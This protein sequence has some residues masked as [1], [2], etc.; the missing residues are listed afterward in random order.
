[1]AS[2]GRLKPQRPGLPTFGYCPRFPIPI[3]LI[4]KADVGFCCNTR[5]YL[6]ATLMNKIIIF[7]LLWVPFLADGQVIRYVKVNGAGD[8]SNWDNASGDLQAMINASG[9][10]AQVWVAQGEYLP[11]D[12]ASFQMKNGVSVYGGFNTTETSLDQRDFRLNTTTLK[13]NGNRVVYNS[14]SVSQTAILDGF[15]ITGGTLTG[16][17][18]NTYGAGIWND[19][20]SA[21]ILNCIIR[22]NQVAGTGFIAKGGGIANTGGSPTIAR[23]VFINNRTSYQGGAIYNE[24][25]T[26]AISNCFF[27]ENRS[28]GDGTGAG[29][30]A[31]FNTGMY[32]YSAV[33]NCVFYAN[34]AQRGGL[35]IQ[36]GFTSN[37]NHTIANC[38]FY[39]NTS[40]D[41]SNPWAARTIHSNNSTL[42]IANT[43]IWNNIGD[44]AFSKQNGS[45]PVYYNSL[46][47]GNHFS[48]DGN[49]DAS[50]AGNNPLF[51][52]TADIA[53]AD[54]FY[55]TADDGLAL[56][57]TS[58]VIDK[59]N[60]T[61][62]TSAG[63]ISTGDSD[64]GNNPRLSGCTIDLGAYENQASQGM[65]CLTPGAG[66]ILYVDINVPGGDGSGDS[67][68]NA[69]PELAA[70]LKWAGMQ[71]NFTSANPLKIYVAKGLYKPMY[72]ARDGADF[73]G[74]NRDNAFVM[75]KNVQLYGGFDPAAGITAPGHS[76]VFT[77]PS[78]GTGAEGT[79]LSGDFDGNDAVTG[80]GSTLSITGNGENAHFVVL[81]VGDLGNA[82]IDGFTIQG[83]Y[84][85]Y[86]GVSPNYVVVNGNTVQYGSGAGMTI[87]MFDEA[88]EGLVRNCNFRYN[89]GADYGGGALFM[90][91]SDVTVANSIF[92]KNRSASN[93]QRGGAIYNSSSIL[94]VTNSLFAGNRAD[95]QG[96]AVFT[97]YNCTFINCT[98][99]ENHGGNGGHVIRRSSGNM[100]FRNSILWNSGATA[101]SMI[102]GGNASNMRLTNCIISNQTTGYGTDAAGSNLLSDPLFTN[103]AGGDFTL[104]SGSPAI[105]AG[106]NSL[107]AGLDANTLDLAG[108]PR[109]VGTDIDMGAYESPDGGLPV[110][111]I[112][113]EGRLSDQ[114]QAV[115][116]WKT[117]ETNVSHY[118]V[119]RSA[120]ARQFR[121]TA[122]VAA[123]TTGSGKY[124][125]PDPAPVYGT[126]YYRIRQVDFDG[127]FSY[128]GI[129]SVRAAGG[130]ALRAYPNP[131]RDAV[132]VE[133]G[134][135]H[136]GSR[137]SLLNAAGI[138]LQQVEI[139][140]ETLTIDLHPYTSG[141]YLLHIPG[142][143]VVKVI[144]E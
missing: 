29:G 25:A 129:I 48:T 93:T 118:E 132:T 99:S 101:N 54:G 112:S 57:S 131:T 80:A 44:N 87:I 89:D 36:N 3:L 71:N 14:W 33:R 115:L 76:R 75:V 130:I 28:T 16:S 135:E 119:Q 141:V 65:L 110:R 126:V 139:K 20:S 67:W 105:N 68:T 21:R 120:D 6:K 22:D 79:V 94:T 11:A 92:E 107:F 38:T 4:R 91:N 72:S 34:Q 140:T 111:W 85:V 77:P 114:H 64:I 7:L 125:L 88:G 51:V 142:G 50:D 35:A 27:S 23:C 32:T 81:A 134:N 121:I 109:L 102:S 113:F 97:N 82:F 123:G 144:R 9:N 127:T 70:A 56:Q 90:W 143:K 55:G 122:T 106:N 84:N 15:T 61:H 124:S 41:P 59:G 62:Y 137:V 103:A 12:G 58:P 116:T 1:M 49:L 46:V 95:S 30:G 117:E 74:E 83:G 128:S 40:A 96:G 100:N 53:G 136:I 104:G 18:E 108:G 78:G 73:A 47:Q 133:L 37:K 138:V 52:N 86:D 69:I 19:N 39:R 60:N 5:R 45:D 98:F 26:P 8:G 43:V 42:T 17:G 24:N 13:G 10:G 31:I 63:G 66:N 2:F